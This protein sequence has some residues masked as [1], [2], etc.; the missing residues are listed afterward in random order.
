MIGSGAKNYGSLWD[1]YQLFH[2]FIFMNLLVYISKGSNYLET[3]FKT[4]K[5]QEFLHIRNNQLLSF[6]S[7]ALN[8]DNI[9][10]HSENCKMI[11]HS[12]FEYN[13]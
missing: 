1:G 7:L 8:H 3:V 13:F 9:L 10:V 11:I 4:G 12:I 5:E 6:D 2:N